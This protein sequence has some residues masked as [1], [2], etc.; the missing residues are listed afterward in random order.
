LLDRGEQ[1]R[2]IVIDGEQAPA[3]GFAGEHAPRTVLDAT[4]A[5]APDGTPRLDVLEAAWR[6][7]FATLGVDPR[8]HP[9]LITESAL[10]R[11]DSREAIVRAMFERLGVPRLLVGKR[12]VLA[13]HA[14]DRSTGIAIVVTDDVREIVPVD[15]GFAMLPSVAVLPP[16]ESL[17]AIAALACDR[18]MDCERDLRGALFASVVL[19]G[20]GAE[21]DGLADSL[22]ARL[23][24][25]APRSTRVEVIAP[26]ARRHLT[27]R[28]AARLAAGSDAHPRWMTRADYDVHGA[29]YI[30]RRCY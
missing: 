3:V 18:V 5:V 23:L 17:E 2:A 21:D 6:R 19:A 27:R 22:L 12:G 11:R 16:A 30:H 13:L 1:V 24:A 29:G 10:A 4:G 26:A 28:G 25:L 9:V 14:I 8:H 20:P 15:D 7:A